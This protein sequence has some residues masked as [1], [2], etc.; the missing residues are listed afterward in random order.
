[1][2]DH[3]L[4][5]NATAFERAAS[6][7][8]DHI[9]RLASGVDAIRTAKLVSIPDEYL[10]FLIYE[11]GLGPVSAYIS[12]QRLLITS[13]IAWQRVRGT[14]EAIARALSWVGYT[15]TIEEARVTRRRWNLFQLGMNRLRDAEVPD[16]ENIE[17]VVNLSVAVRSHF[18]RAHWGYDVREA[19]FSR[20]KWSGARYAGASGARLRAGGVKW[21][22]GRAHDFAV[23]MDRPVLQSLGAWVEPTQGGTTGW[24]IPTAN[25]TPLTAAGW[26]G[27]AWDDTN[28]TWLGADASR[29]QLIAASLAGRTIWVVLR[30]GNGSV[31]G[32]RRARA[33]HP[34]EGRVGGVYT[35]AGLPYDPQV[36]G[37]SVYVEALTDFGEG[38]GETAI[39]ASLLFDAVPVDPA[40]P[41]LQWALPGE[42]STG[43]EVASQPVNIP[44]GRTVRERLRFL[45]TF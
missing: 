34:V 19:E 44:M 30:R 40:R 45:L 14:P 17:G 3:L 13:G 16:L 5:S 28:L 24:G 25:V 22:Y 29:E 12:D 2:D 8:M 27:F 10:P 6:R 23:L 38:N 39:S 9:P 31:I 43:V 33:V 32:Y 15:A 4:P 26:G 18:Y 42:L 37:R 11:Y 21:S 35:V 1:M 41:G 36:G 20:R 7:T